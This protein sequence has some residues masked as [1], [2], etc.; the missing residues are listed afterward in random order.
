MKETKTEIMRGIEGEKARII[1]NNTVEFYRGVER[2][3]R[4]HH[5]DIVVF[6]PNG[7][8]VLNSNGWRTPTTKDRMNKFI[9]PWYISQSNKIWHISN[10]DGNQFVYADNMI[11][12][13][14]GT[15]TGAGEDP[16]R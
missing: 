12:H 3:I 11:L 4:L 6:R 9:W 8:I 10:D 2:A 7:D 13:N 5:T 16:A 1:A 14:D 15:V